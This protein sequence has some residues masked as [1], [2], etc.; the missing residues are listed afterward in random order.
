MVHLN[1]I[2]LLLSIVVNLEWSIFQLAAKIV[3]SMVMYT[4]KFTWSNLQGMLLKKEYS[5]QT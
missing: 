4:K 5:L 2:H 3:S 1:P